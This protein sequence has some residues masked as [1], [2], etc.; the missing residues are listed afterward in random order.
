MNTRFRLLNALLDSAA[1]T[2]A[3]IVDLALNIIC[4][5]IIAPGPLEKVGFALVACVVVLFAVR[6]WVVGNKILWAVFALVSVFFD[7]S[8]TLVATDVQT[9]SNA[10]VVTVENDTELAFLTVKAERTA[11]AVVDLQEQYRKA[12]RRA[13]MDQLDEQ[14]KTATKARNEAETARAE[15]LARIESGELSRE[16]VSRRAVITAE[17]IFGAILTAGQKGRVLPIVIF[18]MIFS[19]LQVVMVT[20]ANSIRANPGRR[21]P[22]RRKRRPV[23]APPSVE[24]A[25]IRRWLQINWMGFRQGKTDAILPRKTFFSFIQNN[26]EAITDAQYDAILGAAIRENIIE[27]VLDTL[28]VREHNEIIAAKKIAA[29]LAAPQ[30]EAYVNKNL[31][32][33]RH[34]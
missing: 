19:G 34:D 15:R 29:A 23:P 25:I 1:L 24:P 9:Q 11:A 30:E 21:A 33:Q 6:S 16:A 7:L 32:R 4:M 18:S 27:K 28:V 5:V 17:M 2:I 20:A 3:L 8:F 31:R 22:T 26:N 12:M 10:V 13:T 14:I